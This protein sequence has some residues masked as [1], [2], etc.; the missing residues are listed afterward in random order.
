MK[1]LLTF[2]LLFGA[3]VGAAAERIPV[4]S[5]GND[6]TVTV[7]QSTQDRIVVRF[8]VGEFDKSPIDVNGET[9][10][11]IGCGKEGI[12]LNAGEPAV[13]HVC[14]SVIIPD[15]ADMQINVLSS[16]YVDFPGTPVVPS[17]G[18]LLRTVDPAD[19]PYT[20]GST[21]TL[22]QQ[23]PTELASARAPYILRDY[24]GTVIEVFPFQYLPQTQTLRVYSSVTVELVN[25]GRSDVNVLHRDR[26]SQP[27]VP[28]FDQIYQRRFVNYAQETKRY[29]PVQESGD[30]LIIS[31]D[32]FSSAMQPFVDWKRQKG[33]A[34][35]MVNI[36]TIGNTANQIK[37]FVQSFYDTTNLAWVLLVGDA[38][39][40]ATPTASG[41]SSDPSYAKV[42]GS[43]DYPDIFVG[44]FSSE[45]TADAQTQV[46]RTI[47]YERD[48]PGSDWFHKAIGVASDQGPG[49]NGGE[50]DYQHMNVIRTDLLGYTY[51]LVDQ[52]YDP[53]ATAT[54]VSNALNNG[55]SFANYCG[56]GS[57]D[58]WSTSGF[59]SSNVNALTNTDML[60]F[61]VSVACVNGQ[62]AGYTCFAEAWLRARNGGNPTGAIG[63]YMSSINQSWNPPMDAQDEVTDLLIANSMT[64]FGGLCYNGSCKMIDINGAGGIEMYNTW[65]IFGDPSVQVRTAN[66]IPM[67]VNHTGTV[68]FNATGYAVEVV[69]TPKALCAL[70]YNGTLYGS[71]YTLANGT[72]IIPIN[73]TLPFGATLTLTITAYNKQT[74]V[75]S[76]L[77]ASDLVIVH[78]PL[79]DTKNATTPYETKCAIYTSSTLKSDSLLLRYKIGAN[80]FLDTLMETMPLGNYVGYI[81]PQPAGTEISYYLFAVNNGGFRDS[82]DLATFRVI[83][84]AII[85]SPSAIAT[86]AAVAD[87]VWYSFTATN[88]GV[89]T[90]QYALSVYGSVWGASAWDQ[91][92]TTPI[93]SI[94]PL[95]MD[96]V[97]PFKLRVIVPSSPSGANDLAHVSL[98]SAGKPSLVVEATAQTYSAGQPL[99]VPFFDDFATTQ[100]DTIRWDR[101]AGAAVDT[102]GINPPSPP[103]SLNLNGTPT[104]ADTLISDKINLRGLSGINVT[105][106]FEKKGG[107]D[108]PESGDDLFVEYYNSAGSWGLL[109]Q[110]FGSDP[111]MTSFQQMTAG[112]PPDGYHAQ[113]RLR[114]RNIGTVGADDWFVDNIRIDYGPAISTTPS[115]CNES[116]ALGDSTVENLIIANTGLGALTYSLVS[117]PDFSRTTRL[118]DRLKAEGHVNP[119][120]YAAPDGWG[121][122]QEVKGAADAVRG[123]EVVYNA[124]GPDAFGYI[125]IDSDQPG[126][127]A[128]GW[129]D[130]EFTGTNVSAGLVDDN[131]VGPFP[132][133]FA[134]PY[135]DSCYSQFWISSNGFIGF[136]PATDYNTLGNVGMPSTY[137]PNNIVA[138]CWDDLNIIDGNNPGG[139]V[140]YQNVGGNLVVQ[141]VKYPRLSSPVGAVI[142][143]E[144][145]LYPNGNIKVQYQTIGA[146]FLQ[147]SN[148]IGMENKAGTTGL[149][150][151]YNTT[152]LHDNLALQFTRPAQW[153]WLS[154][155]SGD[156]PSGAADTISMK[157]TTTDLDT[158]IYKSIIKIY[159]NDPDVSD[160]P[161][162]ISAKLTVLPP[163]QCGDATS[164]NMVNVTDVV[165][166]IDYIFAG[167]PPPVPVQRG[168]VNCDSIVNISDV[169]YLISFV[170][171]GGTAPCDAC[172]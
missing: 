151:A 100:L 120:S 12:L 85:L 75:G 64:T 32:A 54:M 117:I 121:N 161:L 44:R 110:H 33:I 7:E 67:I 58:A 144:M 14:R 170:F 42:A 1:L 79:T 107:G 166:L 78:T 103:Y 165:Y 48:S 69:G 66:P 114:F 29:I 137:T 159:S 112:I 168:D 154:S 41:G 164:D 128:F 163:Y 156:I 119:A 172:K 4:G 51:T 5:G 145:I 93:S 84:Y 13:P 22:K 169:T 94:G 30:M 59:S 171:G 65:H 111:D 10:F 50:Y 19:V 46:Q 61:I 2:I 53:G 82:T 136:G 45:S 123:P 37:A 134:F 21:Y 43:D 18:N 97:A 167:G 86:T 158:G 98:T 150:V 118:F 89:L 91:A 24:R 138:W 130:I 125:W 135:Y 131:Y 83:D 127:P 109:R 88:D 31:Y 62:F 55:R 39:Q 71:T 96:Q 87:T 38:A 60:P 146:G 104:G 106:Y 49:H 63:A 148:T 23:Y 72:A 153:L 26:S 52:I 126:G 11:S 143:A 74:F 140:L 34:T 149:Q 141:F 157:F 68:F 70:Y 101:I 162:L 76:V 40:V 139:K 9:Y 17:K 27:L 28:E 152:Y 8:D 77:V 133:G 105:Y 25:V 81:P 36:S 56:H 124:G 73:Q 16:R 57:I 142:T 115:A 80:W 155:A 122:Y 47:T 108:S 116:L 102:R 92:G 99:A 95:A 132:I 113:F 20:F 160:N 3:V 6:V 15:D 35:T 147:T 90:D 129:T